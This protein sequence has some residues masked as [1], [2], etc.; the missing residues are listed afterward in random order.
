MSFKILYHMYMVHV[1]RIHTECVNMF[2]WE[3]GE[4]NS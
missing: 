4:I 1:D 3:E 2:D